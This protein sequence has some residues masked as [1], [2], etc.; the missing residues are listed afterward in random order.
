[1]ITELKYDML[2]YDFS[3]IKIEDHKKSECSIVG[4][5][6]ASEAIK[7]GLSIKKKGYNIYIAGA[8]RSGKTS[9][10]EKFAKEQAEKEKTP[11]D[12]CYV[13]NFD[14]PSSPK[15]LKLKAGMGRELKE[16]IVEIIDR[17]SV[18]I[19]KEF[20][21]LDFQEERERIIK[22]AQSEKDKIINDLSDEAKKFNFGVKMSG[23]GGVYFLPIVDGKTINEDEFEALSDEERENITEGSS[24]VQQLASKAMREVKTID[25]ETKDKLSEIE[26][27]IGIMTVGHIMSGILRKYSSNETVSKFLMQVREDILE[28]ISQLNDNSE[29]NSDDP[30]SAMVPWIL[31]KNNEELFAKYD[32]N[33][34]VDNSELKGAPVIINYNPTYTNLVGEIEYESDNGNF[35]TDFMK[36]KPGLF[37]KAN[38]GYLIFH[39]SDILGNAFTWDTVRRMLKTGH[40]TTEPLKEYQLGG[41]NVAGIQPE[42]VDVD[43]K[44]IIVG[45]YYYYELLKEYDD[46][47]TKLFK[48]CALFDYEMDNSSENRDS[49]IDFIYD[50]VEKKDLK[51]ISKSG[52]VTLLNQSVRLAEKQNKLS[53]R[54]GILGDILIEADAWAKAD[55]AQEISEKYI[56]TAI[57]KKEER[58]NIYAQKYLSMIYSDDIMI[59]SKGEKVGQ[60]NG[61][62]VM[63]GDDFTFG[64]PTRITAGSYIGKAG[65]VNIEKE[66]ELSGSIHDKGIQVLTGYMGMKYAHDFP[67]TFSARIC[68]EQSYNGVDGD[69]ASSTE[70]Y[71]LISSLSEVPI[72]QGLAVTGSM[73]QFGEIQA[74][75]G[76]TYKIEGF[77]NVCK[78]RGLTGTQGVIIPRSNIKDLVLND[79]VVES[80]KSGM[81]HIYAI[82]S[83]DDGIELLMNKKPGTPLKTKGYSRGSVHDLV[84]KKLEK[85]YKQSKSE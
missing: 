23:S 46:D 15:L 85:Y 52:I 66:S 1:M 50:Y 17:L 31:K 40:V 26:Y 7:L 12:L 78:Q 47:F 72:N 80:V 77:Y 59:S 30:M 45:T 65:I 33:I 37:H 83:I 6:V 73:N 34:I 16:D 55:S 8:N 21:S 2:K 60:I 27:N 4:Q 25:S 61:L 62:C 18:E 76:V 84:Y 70:T 49:L 24:E 29:D 75:G 44:I 63:E 3:D 71:C 69:S 22:E 51:P 81:F 35:T 43:V 58:T 19:P 41:I 48:V 13:Y 39:A 36:I 14:N 9:Y 53:A 11:D 38:G 82:D 67:L 57:E 68:F 64:V 32:I 74:I 42:G 54:F 5:K 56:K 10:A 28:N 20:S 79:E